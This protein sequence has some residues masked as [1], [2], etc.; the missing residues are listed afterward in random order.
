MSAG[1]TARIV[2]APIEERQRL[3]QAALTAIMAAMV[4]EPALTTSSKRLNEAW[5]KVMRAMDASN[6]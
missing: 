4:V 5:M 3:M 1:L 2:N 6:A